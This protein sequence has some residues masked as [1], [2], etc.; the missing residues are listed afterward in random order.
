M[1]RTR[2]ALTVLLAASVAFPSTA[3]A[4]DRDGDG[5][6]DTVD[7]DDRDPT[8]YPGAYE[9]CDGMDNDCDGMVDEGCGSTGDADGDGYIDALLGGTDCDDSAPTTYPGA[10]ELCDGMDN[11]C[12][13]LVD[14][15]CGSTGETDCSDRLDNDGDGWVDCLDS[16]CFL[17]PACIATGEVDCTDGRDNDGDGYTDCAD[18]DCAADPACSSTG[19]D[20]DGDGFDN[21]VDCD[22]RDPTVFPGAPELCDGLDN[23]CNG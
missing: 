6:P 1:P 22:D 12:D 16:D 13:G 17:D 19:V 15:G 7:C 2:F 14:E 8:V 10:Y 4:V 5:F 20:L 21:T 11:D 18:R 9:I 3:L 23:D